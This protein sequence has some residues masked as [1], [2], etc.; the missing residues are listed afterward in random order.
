MA[1][2][3]I[4]ACSSSSTT[5]TASGVFPAQGFTGRTVRVEISGDATKWK[6]GATVSFGDGVSVNSVDV[7]SPTD[8]FAE[9]SI[10]P[11]AMPGMRDVTVTS[12]GTFTLTQ[13]FELVAPVELQVEGNPGQGGLPYFTFVNHDPDNLFDLTTDANTGSY[14]NLAINGPA[15]TM[16]NISSATELSI[17]GRV[18]IDTTAT[19]GDVSIVSGPTATQVTSDA[20]TFP[21]AARTP[22]PLSGTATG[23]LTTAGDSVLYSI[24]AAG[25]PSL[26]HVTLS[27]ADMNAQLGAA[28]FTDGT[29]ANAGG[30]HVI[31]PSAG[32]VDVVA[33]DVGTEAPY[34]FTISG[35]GEAL[36]TAAE[37]ND[38]TNGTNA[39]ALAAT[40]PFEQTGGTLS[41]ATD[42]DELVFTVSAANANKSIELITDAGADPN[43]DTAVDITNATGTSFLSGYGGGP[44]DGTECLFG[45]GNCFPGDA[46][47]EDVVSDPLPAGTYYIKISAGSLYAT[48]DKSYL[49]IAWFQ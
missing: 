30:L 10:D 22:T 46:L 44:V 37:G 25:S 27:T 48:T 9:I 6:D 40:L 23:M 26:V 29:W 20:G 43:T 42:V 24:D 35:A 41:S 8:L 11:T 15:G 3:A 5:P 45:T 28:I 33:A 17:Q 36:T 16:W 14:L 21:I 34:T 13:A 4:A 1:A 39:G 12:G 38:T 7:A 32:T 31:L 18:F 2:A 49:A 47:G 19:A